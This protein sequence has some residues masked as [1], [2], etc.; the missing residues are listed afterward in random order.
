MD[1]KDL[2]ETCAYI[3]TSIGV[4]FVAWQLWQTKNQ[5]VTSFEDQLASEYRKL[6]M[7]I[8]VSVLLG[9]KLEGDKFLKI[10]E[11]IYNYIDLSNEQ[12]FLRQIGRVSKKTWEYWRE[13]IESNLSRQAFAQVWNEVKEAVPE[14]FQEL[15]RLERESFASDPRRWT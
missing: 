11:P 12:V 14:S 9:Q 15:R 2:I 13:G 5:A 3:A 8:P 10:R 6:A 4:F 7:E 1:I